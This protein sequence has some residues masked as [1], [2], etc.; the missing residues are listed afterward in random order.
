MDTGKSALAYWL[1]E[2]YSKQL[3][4]LP[5]V[6]GLPVSK[7]KLLPA[8]FVTR[9]S[10]EEGGHVEDAII[11]FD[12]AG[13]QLPLDNMEIREQVV[14]FLSLPYHRNQ[15]F[16]LVYHYPRLVLSRYLPLFQGFLL[17]RPP[18]LIS[19]ASKRQGDELTEMMREA[20][21]RFGQMA[22]SE[23]VKWTYVVAPKQRWQG[24]LENPLPSFW[25]PEL[26][27]IWGDIDFNNRFEEPVMSDA[28]WVALKQSQSTIQHGVGLI[29]AICGQRFSELISGACAPCF[30][31]W[32]L[33]CKPKPK[34]KRFPIR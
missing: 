22:D 21:K 16:L 28:E 19:F 4:L 3:G 25:S 24:S 10:I 5:V 30:A 17:K 8:N 12:E 1:L 9:Q 13:L 32:A 26:R 33:D 7:A 15:V 31:K 18:Y 20:E 23:I 2:K 6:V 14:N 29:C 27:R 11:L 34:D